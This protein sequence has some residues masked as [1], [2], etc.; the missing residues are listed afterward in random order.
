MTQNNLK[1]SKTTKNNQ[2]KNLIDSSKLFVLGFQTQVGTR[3]RTRDVDL[4][5]KK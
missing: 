4:K 1:S 3:F 2:Y 5:T